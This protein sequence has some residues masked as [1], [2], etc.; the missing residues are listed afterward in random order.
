[1]EEA[2][3]QRRDTRQSALEISLAGFTPPS[4]QTEIWEREAR[5]R[6]VC[7]VGAVGWE[8]LGVKLEAREAHA[9]S[10]IPRPSTQFWEERGGARAGVELS[11]LWC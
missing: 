10:L 9:G 11:G 4:F 8:D 1:M 5:A 6:L 3:L 2:R 7:V